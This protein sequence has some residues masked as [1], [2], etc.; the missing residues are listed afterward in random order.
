LTAIETLRYRVTVGEVAAQSG[1]DLATT[2]RELLNLAIATGGDLQVAQSGDIAYVFAPNF[3]DILQQKVWQERWRARLQA[4]WKWLF[5]L[6][7][8]SFGVLL[9]VAIA[10]VVLGIIA[11]VIALQSSKNSD[12]D[13][14][15]EGRSNRSGG[16]GMIFVPQYLFV[17]DPWGPWFPDYYQRR[18]LPSTAE[19]PEMGFLEG[20]FSFLFGDGDPNADLETERYRAIASVIYANGGAVAAEQLTPYLDGDGEAAVLPVLVKFNGFPE[21]SDRGDIVYRFPELQTV[22][23]YRQPQEPP[24]YLAEQTW[25]FSRAGAGNIGLAIGLGIFYLVGALVLGGL[26]GEIAAQELAVGAFLQFVSG[27]YGLLLGYAILFLTVP[28][29]RYLVLQTLVNPPIVRRNQERAARAEALRSPSPE[30]RAKLN[31]ARQW[32]SRLNMIDSKNLA[33]TTETDLLDQAMEPWD[34]P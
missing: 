11:A 25:P 32:A 27:A 8:I 19:K 30:L 1:L 15:S 17:G 7:R 14:R 13:S 5:W 29:V 21:V 28:A 2:Q 24:P 10:I 12:S 33:Y 6:I 3:R 9:I 26:L 18:R 23:A 22:A 34:K 4:L 31:F 16:G 20:V